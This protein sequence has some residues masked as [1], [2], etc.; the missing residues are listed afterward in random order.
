MALS[1]C[2]GVYLP[3]VEEAFKEEGRFEWSL[4]ITVSCELVATPGVLYCF[5]EYGQ[6]YYSLL[7]IFGKK[8]DF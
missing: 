1:F 4:N 3:L 6:G 7:R 2:Y 8:L 5:L